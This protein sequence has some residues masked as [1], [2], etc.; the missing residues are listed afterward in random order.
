MKLVIDGI[1]LEGV[2]A[3]ETSR[4]QLVKDSLHLSSDI[5]LLVSI[6]SKSS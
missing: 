6:L 1:S 3:P 2:K 5:E 4:K